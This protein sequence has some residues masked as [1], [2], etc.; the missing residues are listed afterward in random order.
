MPLR[1]DDAVPAR[2]EKARMRLVSGALPG[3]DDLGIKLIDNL[4]RVR[5]Q[6]AERLADRLAAGKPPKLLGCTVDVHD[7]PLCR[8]LDHDRDR[9]VVEDLV[10]E[11][12]PA[13]GLA[14]DRFQFADV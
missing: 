14:L 10:E 8:L 12:A 1:R 5:E 7:P 13:S 2:I 6:L 4:G 9:N 3:R 11:V